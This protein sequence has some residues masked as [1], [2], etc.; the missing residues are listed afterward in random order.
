MRPE[1]NKVNTPHHTG[2]VRC[3]RLCWKGYYSSATANWQGHPTRKNRHAFASRRPAGPGIVRLD[4]S[5]RLEGGR[6]MKS[7]FTGMDPYIEGHGH[8]WED[9]HQH[10][11]EDIY[12]TLAAALPPN[13]VVR[14]QPRAYVLLTDHE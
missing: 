1:R 13:Y 8:L 10:L 7:P 5:R 14:C 9:F 2:G 12:R 4:A 3:V 11:I 6:V